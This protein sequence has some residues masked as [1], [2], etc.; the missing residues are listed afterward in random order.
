MRTPAL[1]V[2]LLAVL[3]IDA[4]GQIRVSPAGVN[5]NGQG[6]T[7]TFLTFGALRGYVPAEAFWCG[8]L[9]SSPTDIGAK[10]DPATI[11]GLLPA[12]YDQSRTSGRD[13]Y[14]D[15]MSIPPSV[16]RRAYQAAADGRSAEFFYVRRFTSTSGGP[17]QYVT[18]TCRLT[19]GGA[20]V[21]LSLVDVALAFDRDTLVQQV[22]TG[23]PP[24]MSS[25]RL[26]YTGTGRLKGRW[27]V[28]LPGQDF[29]TPLDL[30]T[31]ATL[32]LEQRG[33]QRRYLELERFNVFLPPTG[34]FTLPG[35]DPRRLPTA[36]AGQ[37]V[38]LL[39]IEAS[40]DR[41]GDSDLAAV[42]A[43]L[44]VVHAG[45]V[46]GFPMPVLRYVVGAG[47]DDRPS[48]VAGSGGL[49]PADGAIVRAGDPV[50]LEWVVI[51]QAA[52]YRIEIESGGAIL[53]Q[54][55][56]ASGATAYRLPPFVVEK[57]IRSELTWRL[58]A[59]DAAG[60][61]AATSAWRRLRLG[62]RDR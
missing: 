13:A 50:D 19:G 8:D 33:Q 39:R 25:A 24:P 28:V 40:D 60:A 3:A 11:Y 16:A 43:G 7:S 32:P 42:G 9:I 20:R 46:A 49:R 61:E 54:A 1:V 35:P 2:L 4:R 53:H 62:S 41:E 18:V 36:N 5:V 47:G 37:Y 27:E 26:T 51:P 55:L 57:L 22:A 31:E 29:P 30:L 6:A 52:Y 21:P 45:A 59:V 15:I 34:R 48:V 56:L 23:A 17:D 10:C 12:R 58:V 44:G 14:T 38:L